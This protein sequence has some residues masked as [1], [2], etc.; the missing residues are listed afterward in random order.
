MIVTELITR[1]SLMNVKTAVIIIIAIITDI[2]SI[3]IE[4][5]LNNCHSPYRY[6]VVVLIATDYYYYLQVTIFNV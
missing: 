5:L 2:I 1:E 6:I 3:N 4:T